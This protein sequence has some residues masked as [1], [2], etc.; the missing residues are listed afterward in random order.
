MGPRKR[1]RSSSEAMDSADDFGT[2]SSNKEEEETTPTSKGTGF[3]GITKEEKMSGSVS[4]TSTIGATTKLPS[5]RITSP[6]FG[7]SL[8]TSTDLSSSA[9]RINDDGDVSSVTAY[10]ERSSQQANNMA[11]L[12][13]ILPLVLVLFAVLLFATFIFIWRKILKGQAVKQDSVKSDNNEVIQEVGKVKDKLKD[14]SS[15]QPSVA[16]SMNYYTDLGS[17][18]KRREGALA[19]K[20]NAVEEAQYAEVDENPLPVLKDS[21]PQEGNLSQPVNSKL[22]PKESHEYKEAVVQVTLSNDEYE[23]AKFEGTESNQGYEEAKD[24]GKQD[25]QGYMRSKVTAPFYHTLDPDTPSDSSYTSVSINKQD[26][27]YDTLNREQTPSKP[28]SKTNSDY[29]LTERIGKGDV[30][31]EPSNQIGGDY[32]V[33]GSR[34]ANI[35]AYDMLDRER[36]NHEADIV[37]PNEYN[38]LQPQ[39]RDK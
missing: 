17:D 6:F 31:F 38:I 11:A 4:I 37:S 32:S 1:R 5:G 39:A 21:T 26:G 28:Q 25:D 8:L 9:T 20:N 15:V 24:E 30:S 13:V 12:A 19:N 18:Q 36:R 33:T 29:D 16:S 3:P 2:L 27:G 23:E 35:S 34:S 22:G 14:T 10:N 7:D